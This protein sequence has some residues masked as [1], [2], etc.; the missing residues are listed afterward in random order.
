MLILRH[1][2]P[3]TLAA[4]LLAAA[5]S[6]RAPSAPKEGP[7]CTA[8]DKA[9]RPCQDPRYRAAREEIARQLQLH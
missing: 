8:A 3:K 4:L 9:N 5:Q 6:Y 1:I 7:P 2:D